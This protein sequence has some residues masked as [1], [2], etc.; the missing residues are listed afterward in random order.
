MNKTKHPV[1][2]A[3]HQ[4]VYEDKPDFKIHEAISCYQ[5]YIKY[6]MPDICNTQLDLFTNVQY[7]RAITQVIHANSHWKQQ[8]PY[9]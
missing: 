3:K 6:E 2:C 1:K 5:V 7:N 9:F 4:V 8:A